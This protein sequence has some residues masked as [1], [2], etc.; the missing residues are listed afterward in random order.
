MN[1]NI[2]V[3]FNHKLDDYFFITYNCISI[4]FHV[5]LILV[6]LGLTRN[7]YH[8]KN[9]SKMKN[10]NRIIVVIEIGSENETFNG[11]LKCVNVLTSMSEFMLH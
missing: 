7:L 5:G 1:A 10:R 9:I 3:M 2:H 8:I 11:S 6:Q 4:G